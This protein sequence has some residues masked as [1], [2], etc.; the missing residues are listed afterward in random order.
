MS[1]VYAKTATTLDIYRETPYLSIASG[2][3]SQGDMLGYELDGKIYSLGTI[4]V[5]MND[6]SEYYYDVNPIMD[7]QHMR[8][9]MDDGKSLHSDSIPEEITQLMVVI[10]MEVKCVMKYIPGSDCGIDVNIVSGH[11]D[12]G[13]VLSFKMDNDS[14]CF[15]HDGR[16]LGI[17]VEEKD[18]HVDAADREVHLDI[19]YEKDCISSDVN[20]VVVLKST[21]SSCEIFIDEDGYVQVKNGVLHVGDVLMMK[22]N[23]NGNT[24][25]VSK[26]LSLKIAAPDSDTIQSTDE[27]I[28]FI[29]EMKDGWLQKN[30]TYTVLE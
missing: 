7:L 3:V 2:N 6:G 16:V 24:Y 15:Y 23:K 20:E 19:T 8:V 22:D 21:K 1:I 10:P 14:T 12:I 9:I 4:E 25:I 11:L 17:H 29:I 26:V 5:I 13:D 30:Q 28:R 27:P 18:L